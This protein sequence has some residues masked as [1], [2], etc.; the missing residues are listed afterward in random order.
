M[1]DYTVIS[2]RTDWRTIAAQLSGVYLDEVVVEGHSLLKAIA[3]VLLPKGFGFCLAPWPDSINY[4]DGR[5]R[6]ELF[7]FSLHPTEE[8]GLAPILADPVAGADGAGAPINMCDDLGRAAQ[9]QRI[10]ILRDAHRVANSITVVGDRRRV[11]V[12][13]NF[14]NTTSRDLEPAWNTT[15]DDLTP[16]ALN[17]VIPEMDSAQYSGQNPPD[18]QQFI[19]RYGKGGTQYLQNL[20]VFRTFVWNE[21][22]AYCP[23]VAKIPDLGVFLGAS[24]ARRPRPLGPTLLYPAGKGQGAPLPPYV[25][26]GIVGD[27]NSWIL[28]PEA[29]IL[30]DR[31]GFTITARRLDLFYPYRNAPTALAGKYAAGAGSYSFATLLYN[32]LRTGGGPT[33]YKLRFRLIGTIAADDA[34]KA[35]A[36]LPASSAWPIAA[37]KTIFLPQRFRSSSL[38][39]ASNPDTL[40]LST[41]DDTTAASDCVWD[42]LNASLDAMG[43]GSIILR[44]LTRAYRP[45]MAFSR[46]RGRGVDLAVGPDGGMTGVVSVRWIFEGESNK[47]ELLLDSNLLEVAR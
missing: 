13:L 42:I 44:S 30:R 6:H 36:A 5:C 40:P 47:T 18:P 38:G 23:T 22:G 3:A 33:D 43:H 2:P 46:T 31:A 27:D 32:T 26:I 29:R 45:G 11:Q 8:V 19:D 4:S 1:D 41:A 35:T 15:Q 39:G 34:V 12:C 17:S 16:W 9:V 21:D 28:L 20:D 37:S 10:E 25:E 14:D 7:V 24:F